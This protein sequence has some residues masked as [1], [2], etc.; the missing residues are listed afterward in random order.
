[1]GSMESNS[2][3][4]LV[5]MF[6]HSFG[7]NFMRGLLQE[8]NLLCRLRSNGGYHYQ[9]QIAYKQYK[10]TSLS[11]VLIHNTNEWRNVTTLISPLSTILFYVANFQL[12]Q[13]MEF[14]FTA[15]T[16]C[17]IFVTIAIFLKW[18]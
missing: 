16:L 10:H 14:P 9:L 11:R 6:L 8:T 2:A 12:P 1:M 5:D 18:L 3:P 15:N 17:K 4:L 13:R 7:A